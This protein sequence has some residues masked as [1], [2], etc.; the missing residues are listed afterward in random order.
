MFEVVCP[1]RI[2]FVCLAIY[3][4]EPRPTLCSPFVFIVR[5]CLLYLPTVSVPM[6]LTS[7]LP[8]LSLYP[9]VCLSVPPRLGVLQPSSRNLVASSP[10]LGPLIPFTRSSTQ[11]NIRVCSSYRVCPSR[12]AL[13]SKQFLRTIITV[14]SFFRS[15]LPYLPTYVLTYLH[16]YLHTY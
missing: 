4:P 16:T 13:S 9:G 8:I 14:P 12:H 7:C 2:Y 3:P 6:F 1:T 10:S 15:T 11:S 5:T